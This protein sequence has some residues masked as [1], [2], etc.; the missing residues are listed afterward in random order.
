MHQAAKHDRRKISRKT[1]NMASL[2]LAKHAPCYSME[3]VLIF[4]EG[5]GEGGDTKVMMK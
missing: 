5:G 2:P 1:E 3:W 4:D